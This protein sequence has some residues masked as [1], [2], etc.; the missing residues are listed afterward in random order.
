MSVCVCECVCVCA[1]V[2]VVASA[3]VTMQYHGDQCYGNWCHGNGC[4]GNWCHGDQHHGDQQ[5][6]TC[7]QFAPEHWIKIKYV[8]PYNL[9]N[10]L[11]TNYTPHQQSKEYDIPNSFGTLRRQ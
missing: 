11:K 5:P 9:Q 7:W 4:Y 1:C 2:C 10:V 6:H 3:M 8:D